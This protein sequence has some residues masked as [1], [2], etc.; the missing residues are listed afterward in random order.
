ME[1]TQLL[2]EILNELKQINNYIKNYK[3]I[4]SENK[5]L[6]LRKQGKI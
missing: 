2:K 4:E 5:L 1:Q 6:E 3:I